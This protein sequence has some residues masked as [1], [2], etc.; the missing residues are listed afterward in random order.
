MSVRDTVRLMANTR[1]TQKQRGTTR[2]GMCCDLYGEGREESIA[3]DK[4]RKAREAEEKRVAKEAADAKK[5]E[6]EAK[7]AE[8]ADRLAERARDA[9][10]RADLEKIGDEA[11]AIHSDVPSVAAHA[12]AERERRRYK[13]DEL[14]TTGIV[15]DLPRGEE[16]LM[17]RVANFRDKEWGSY[18]L[19]LSEDPEAYH[20]IRV[21]DEDLAKAK[22]LRTLIQKQ[23][24]K[25]SAR[26]YRTPAERR[27]EE[28]KARRML[29]AFIED[30]R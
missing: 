13:P 2:G 5:A 8:E 25:A 1:S 15:G 30:A 19:K 10:R 9:K 4:A 28:E 26:V 12:R 6:K 11:A 14:P 20:P 22:R 17:D 27:A 16:S 21:P 18:L 7:E 23:Q 3:Y 24:Q 29:T